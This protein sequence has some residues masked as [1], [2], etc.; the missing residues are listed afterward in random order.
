[1]ADFDQAFEKM[2]R[3]EGGYKLHNVPGDS[4]GTTYAG[5]ARNFHPDWPGWA[6]IDSNDTE[7]PTLT[8]QVKRFYQ[9]NFW[10]KI[11]GGDI[12]LQGI[13]ETLFDFAVNAGH[14]TAVKLAQLILGTTPDGIIG[15]ITLEKLNQ[16][17]EADEF[18]IRYT[19]AK[20]ARYAEIVNRD[21]S[22]SK[23]LLGWINRALKE[24]A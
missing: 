10:A 21:R 7:N 2:I 23:F 3:N 15:P 17:Q 4:G 19:L 16:L 14:K 1:M 12:Q 20:V 11:K 22:Q 8:K 6:Y 13:A 9:D 24:A 18:R 5:I